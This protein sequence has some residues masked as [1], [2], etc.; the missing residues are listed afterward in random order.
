[1]FPESYYY[2]LNSRRDY[3]QGH[4][5]PESH[6]LSPLC[7]KSRNRG[8]KNGTCL[9]NT[10]PTWC[11]HTTLG[12]STTGLATFSHKYKRRR[13]FRDVVLRDQCNRVRIIQCSLRSVLTRVSMCL[14]SDTDGSLHSSSVSR[15]QLQP[16]SS[17]LNR[18]TLKPVTEARDALL[19]KTDKFQ[20][21][22]LLS[23][24]QTFPTKVSMALSMLS[25]RPLLAL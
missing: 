8:G 22:T 4:S 21:K 23:A 11:S 16:P 6:S 20:M 2:K 12:I 9:T 5:C 25:F 1:M 19:S 24:C 17:T 13:S 3:T 10:L 18:L 15:K 7:R 14:T